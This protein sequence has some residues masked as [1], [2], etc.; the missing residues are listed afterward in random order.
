MTNSEKPYCIA[1]IG[2]N[3]GGDVEV[4]RDLIDI[5]ALAGAD[6]VKL[7]K[8]DNRTLFTRSAYN[9]SYEGHAS[10]GATYGEHREALELG[11]DTFVDLKGHAENKGL[12]FFATPFDIASV[13]FLKDIGVTQF[14]VASASVTNH[15]LLRRIAQE[16][17]PVF[18][19]VGG[20]SIESIKA[21]IK[22]F[23][24]YLAK[25]Q[26]T[27]LHCVAAYPC[28][29]EEMNLLRLTQF[30]TIFPHRLGLSDHQDGIALGAAAYVLG[31]RVFEKHITLDHSA[32]GTDHAFS[33]E[34]QGLRM[35]INYL[36]DAADAIKWHEQPTDSEVAAIEKM[37]QSLY[38]KHS[39][40]DGVVI[41]PESIAIQSPGGFLYPTQENV[42]QF[43]GNKLK[44]GVLEGEPLDLKQ[45]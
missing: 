19:S 21:A 24:P 1:E 40:S 44:K 27:I 37:A 22:I 3:H 28:P 7:Q 4:A 29:P 8:R 42:A 14:K 10:Y 11:F 12:D 33:L 16:Q 34:Y 43:V 38:W 45:I 2:S 23:A 30:R 31:A 32:K 6:A 35:Y 13:E 25:D 36:N 20:Q 17:L 15:L 18:M 41:Q 9:R 5:A 26:L 39:I